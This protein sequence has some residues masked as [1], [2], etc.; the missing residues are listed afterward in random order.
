[1]ARANPANRLGAIVAIIGAAGSLSLLMAA[2]RHTPVGLLILFIGWVALP[3]AALTAA[4]FYA[5]QWFSLVKTP[6][7]IISVLIALASLFIYGWVTLWPPSSTPARTWLLVPAFSWLLII[8]V[9]VMAY[10]SN[11]RTNAKF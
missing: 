2:G 1:M 7:L 8:A 4:N 3:F 10:L 5:T 6:L 9:I 11:R